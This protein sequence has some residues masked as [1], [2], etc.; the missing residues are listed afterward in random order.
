MTLEC[1]EWNM[2]CK[3]Y[4]PHSRMGYA[5]YILKIRIFRTK[6]VQIAT[7][8][9][10]ENQSSTTFATFMSFMCKFQSFFS[11][12]QVS[13]S[14]GLAGGRTLATMT[15]LKLS[16]QASRLALLPRSSPFPCTSLKWLPSPAVPLLMSLLC[17]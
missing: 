5:H 13:C 11:A 6:G 2:I 15:N 3:E 9:S 14:S 1:L 7:Y 4:L 8:T 16:M 10:F 12:W 17:P